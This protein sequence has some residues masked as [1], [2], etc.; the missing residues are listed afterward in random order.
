MFEEALVVL[1]TAPDHETAARIGRTL[2]EEGLAACANV[3]PQIRSIYRWQGEI[4]DEGETLMLIKTTRSV[5]ARLTERI[6]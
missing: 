1:V 6:L 2:V 5:Q 4:N 3:L